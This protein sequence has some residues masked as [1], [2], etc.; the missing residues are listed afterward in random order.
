MRPADLNRAKR[1]I[2]ALGK[3]IETNI[4]KYKAHLKK[5]E[6]ELQ[7]AISDSNTNKYELLNSSTLKINDILEELLRLKAIQ[8]DLMQRLTRL[9]PNQNSDEA[10][11]SKIVYEKLSCSDSRVFLEPRIQELDNLISSLQLQN[12]LN[13]EPTKVIPASVA[14]G[15]L[16]TMMAPQSV[17]KVSELSKEDYL[18]RLLSFWNRLTVILQDDKSKPISSMK[19][20]MLGIVNDNKK[21]VDDKIIGFQNVILATARGKQPK[22]LSDEA[23]AL[24][25]TV[26]QEVGSTPFDLKKLLSREAIELNDFYNTIKPKVRRWDFDATKES[27]KDSRLESLKQFYAA[28]DSAFKHTNSDGIKQMKKLIKQTIENGKYLLINDNTINELQDKM[29]KIAHERLATK[30]S[31]KDTKRFFHFGRTGKAQKFYE[32][33]SDEKFS[34]VDVVSTKTGP[35]FF[36]NIET[37]ASSPQDQPNFKP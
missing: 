2:E 20:G 18:K 36:K 30:E 21:S 34:L 11:W 26:N 13:P 22:N 4:Q 16:P 33:V 1:D 27:L 7:D 12:P 29:L 10:E 8:V 32:I 15:S 31:W 23:K 6:P 17:T 9:S 24:F 25:R 35:T 28:F 3:F 14:V 19:K 37:L 5:I